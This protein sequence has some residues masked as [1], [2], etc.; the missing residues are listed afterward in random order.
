MN[1]SAANLMFSSKKLVVIYPELITLFVQ[2]L[3]RQSQEILTHSPPTPVTPRSQ[4]TFVQWLARNTDV[5]LAGPLATDPQP[6]A[7]L[8]Y[9]GRG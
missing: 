4:L 5:S 3:V 7:S 1:S 9:L 8:A 2:L 6:M